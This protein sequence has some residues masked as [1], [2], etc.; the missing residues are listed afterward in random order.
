MN[1]I[2]N[3]CDSFKTNP[4]GSDDVPNLLN[5]KEI[6]KAHYDR[7]KKRNVENN[8][9]IPVQYIIIHQSVDDTYTNDKHA[10]DHS[11]EVN[12][13]NSFHENNIGSNNTSRSYY[14]DG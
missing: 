11:V 1:T 14:P 13:N 4:D 12:C 5:M 8:K 3:I 6:N 10:D 2:N 7:I 9:T